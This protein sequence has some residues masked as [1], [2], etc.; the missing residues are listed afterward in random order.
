MMKFRPAFWKLFKKGKKK[1]PA[2]FQKISS[3]KEFKLIQEASQLPLKEDPVQPIRIR[4]EKY[5]IQVG[6]DFGTSATKAVY[7]QHGRPLRKV[8]NFDHGL[9]NYPNYCLPSLAAVDE[10]GQLLLGVDAATMHIMDEWDI[11]FQRF[12]VLVAGNQ[13]DNFFDKRTHDQFRNY[14][15]KNDYPEDFTPEKLSAI[16]L[17]HVMHIC[18]E[19]IT[20]FSEYKDRE[21]EIAFNICMPIEHV[22]NNKVRI[23]FERIFS[24]AESIEANWKDLYLDAHKIDFNSLDLIDKSKSRV[25][26][27][28]EAVAGLAS[29]LISLRREDGIHAIIDLGAG[30]TDLSI[31]NLISQKEETYSYWYAARNILSGTTNIEQVIAA[32]IKACNLDSKCCCT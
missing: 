5:Y 27:I 11:G 23:E 8:L 24:W 31:C 3:K 28:P 18:R 13:D 2:G 19:K 32:H 22:E 4:K 16:Y 9:P 14:R 1:E 17:A 21:I 20:N 25:S 10:R 15:K 26:A 29:Y 12:K 7:L 30:T 6:L